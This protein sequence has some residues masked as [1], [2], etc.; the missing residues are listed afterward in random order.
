MRKSQKKAHLCLILSHSQDAFRVGDCAPHLVMPPNN[1]TRKPALRRAKKPHGARA[2]KNPGHFR[3]HY[4]LTVPKKE[5]DEP[6]R[7]KG[8]LTGAHRCDVPLQQVGAFLRAHHPK[9]LCAYEIGHGDPLK[10]R[11]FAPFCAQIG[12]D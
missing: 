1:S 8:S 9:S 10:T 12:A 11:P 4:C 2:S 6:R 7:P 5:A 3:R